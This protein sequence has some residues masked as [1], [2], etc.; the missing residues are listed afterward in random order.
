MKN[1]IVEYKKQICNIKALYNEKLL[2]F[3]S[4]QGQF[5]ELQDNKSQLEKS[6]E[7]NFQ[8]V[9]IIFISINKIIIY[10]ILH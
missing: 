7:T 2:E 3:V 5:N 1:D 10:I 4:L 6:F 9:Y 8:V